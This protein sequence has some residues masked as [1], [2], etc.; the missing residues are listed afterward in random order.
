MPGIVVTLLGTKSTLGAGLNCADD[1]VVRMAIQIL[2][3]NPFNHDGP[4][5]T[6][7]DWMAAIRKKFTTVPNPFI[8]DRDITV[9]DPYVVHP[10]DRLPAE[11][12]SLIR[13]QD[14]V[15]IFSFQVMVRHHR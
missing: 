14:Q 11:S 6:Y 10:I 1:E 3:H 4:L 13:H 7:L 5:R 2:D 12:Q 8:Q 9:Y 15:A